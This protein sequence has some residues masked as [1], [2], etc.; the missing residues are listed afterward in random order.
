MKA[1]EEEERDDDRA[2]MMTSGG[3]SS[4]RVSSGRETTT[5]G[6]MPIV[7]AAGPSLA[8]RVLS[9]CFRA[10]ALSP[11]D[12]DDEG[13][14]RVVM[15]A[16]GGGRM[17]SA[18]RTST[19]A[20]SGTVAM[21]RR[22]S[23]DC[24]LKRANFVRLPNS[25]RVEEC[26][27]D[28]VCNAL[29][30]SFAFEGLEGSVKRRVANAMFLVDVP[31]GWTLMHQGEEGDAL[32][33]IQEGEFDVF[34]DRL[35]T[36]VKVVTRGPGELVGE[37]ALLYSVPRMATVRAKRASKVWVCTREVFKSE[38]KLSVESNALSKHVFI[39]Q[40]PAMTQLDME[41][42]K[43]IARAMY[44]VKFEPGTRVLSEGDVIGDDAKFYM[45]SS[46]SAT[47]TKMDPNTKAER[48]VNRLFRHD[49]SA[50]RKS[51]NAPQCSSL[52]S[53]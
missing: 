36:P 50:K 14:E 53:S 19:D 5:S 11:M 39:E 2:R 6:A 52:A 21:K 9:C 4:G 31:E 20:E 47:V 32:Y 30:Q 35:G 16:G 12:S 27:L 49:F 13:E 23:L 45:V 44:V 29:S 15:R 3:R 34:E 28:A 51:W 22:P 1:R 24:T 8:L 33:L 42:R 37:L 7:D 46:G 48:V 25:R 41:T 10:P 38:V 18:M 40:V 26:E 17:T 43:K